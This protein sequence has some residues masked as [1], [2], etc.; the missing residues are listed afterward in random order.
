MPH[1]AL[2]NGAQL[3]SALA[4]AHWNVFCQFQQSRVTSTPSMVRVD[5]PSVQTLPVF[6][7]R[8]APGSTSNGMS[9]ERDT[10][11]SAGSAGVIASKLW[12]PFDQVSDAATTR[13]RS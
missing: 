10:A 3:D 13:G 7:Q 6:T 5:G 12:Q 4:V 9:G 11:P 2:T 8:V 1:P